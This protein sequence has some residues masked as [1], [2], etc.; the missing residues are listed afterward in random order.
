MNQQDRPKVE[1]ISDKEFK[2]E[3]F[4]VRVNKLP[5]RNAKYSI[6][7][8]YLTDKDRESRFIPMKSSGQGKIVLDSPMDKL[9]QLISQAESYIETELQRLEDYRI[10]QL[11]GREK[12]DLDRGKPK[13][14]RG[15]KAWGQ[16]DKA[17]KA[18]KAP[19]EETA[20]E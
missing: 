1:W 16:A 12:R 3:C 6:S 4:I 7:I 17:A 11:E 14:K 20:S 2:N 15:I 19:V 5:I 18:A 13:Q 9:F 10:E 8:S